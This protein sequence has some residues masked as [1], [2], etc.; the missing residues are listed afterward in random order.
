MFPTPIY[1]IIDI[2]NHIDY[3]GGTDYSMDNLV[4]EYIRSDLRGRNIMVAAV[5]RSSDVRASETPNAVMTTLASPSLCGTRDLSL[6]RV[7]ARAGAVGP[8][9]VFDS[10]QIWTLVS[11]EAS[12]IVDGETFALDAGDTIQLAANVTRQMNIAADA[13]FIVSG[14][15]SAKATTPGS[16][17][18]GITPP[19]IR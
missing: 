8:V 10:E 15:G 18:D 19:W 5:T 7:H 13:E 3:S 12:F 1:A 17:T 4:D 9:H 16:G 2:D 11:G 14:Y 6:W